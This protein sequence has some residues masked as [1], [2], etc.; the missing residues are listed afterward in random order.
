MNVSR[1]LLTT[2]LLAALGLSSAPA[3]AQ[4]QALDKAVETG[5][6]K[7]AEGQQSQAKI[8]KIVDAQQAKLIEYRAL[9]KQQD[10][11]E[12]YNEQLSTQVKSQEALIERFDSS[13]TQVAK[14]ER[15][16][17]PLTTRMVE[18]LSTFVELDLPFH[19][20]ERL[21]RI[22]FVQD[23]LQKADLNVAE[24][25]RQVLEAYQIE[26]DY[27][28]K[29]D[30][31]Q[32]IVEIDGQQREV[33]ILRMGRVALVAQT[34]DATTTAVWD[35]DAKQWLVL[36]PGTYR[37]SVRQGIR[38]AKKQASIDLVSLPIPAPTAAETN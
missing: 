13:I 4:S 32:R 11:L 30:T 19:E 20:T 2:A 10:G 27:G 18:A 38:M 29:I 17:L 16:M 12:Q 24:K 8:D 9:L 28:R 31:Y 3:I 26:N 7:V 37:N 21:E 23:S 25:F 34:K 14:I 36:D 35:H 1:P 5:Q 15:Q 33:D 22:A 6:Q